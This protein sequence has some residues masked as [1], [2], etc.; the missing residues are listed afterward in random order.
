L[1]K[2]PNPEAG[3]S[4]SLG[5]SVSLRQKPVSLPGTRVVCCG[6]LVALTVQEILDDQ[7]AKRVESPTA[8]SNTFP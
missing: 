5:A 8:F 2:Q 6:D 1:N 7:F 3:K 4:G